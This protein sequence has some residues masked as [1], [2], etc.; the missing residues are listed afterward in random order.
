MQNTSAI[1]KALVALMDSSDLQDGAPPEFGARAGTKSFAKGQAPLP[2]GLT[3]S[4]RNNQQPLRAPPP[5]IEV[6][7]SRLPAQSHWGI[8]E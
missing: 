4:S 7:S 5:A 1:V 2:T 3:S 6:G 8:N